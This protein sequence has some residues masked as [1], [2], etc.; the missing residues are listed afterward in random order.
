[1]Y[2]INLG[3]SELTSYRLLLKWKLTPQSTVYQLPWKEESKVNV[4]L[5]SSVNA[6]F[7]TY[8]INALL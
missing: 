1:M 3:S 7:K 5:Q 8:D 4:R 2:L 6:W